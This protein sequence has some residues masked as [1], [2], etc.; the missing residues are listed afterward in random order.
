MNQ[1]GLSNTTI[2]LM[3]STGVLFDT[4]QWLLAFIFMDWLVGIFAFL[5]FYVWFR[6]KGMKFNTFKRAGTLSTALFIEIIPWLSLLPAWTAS[7]VVLALDSKIKKILP[8]SDI[9][10]S[11]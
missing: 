2:A 5:T 11:K 1:E 8:K 9:I 10:N 7:I 4:I 6:T 3:V